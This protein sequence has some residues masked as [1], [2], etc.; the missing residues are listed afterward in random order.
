MS[1]KTIELKPAKVLKIKPKGK[2]LL[3]F[4]KEDAGNQNELVE[5]N[6]RIKELFGNARV[7]AIFSKDVDSV[8]I[9]ELM[10]VKENE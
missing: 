6:E 9:A 10:E 2:Y 5:L 7:L 8:K 4:D 1:K 3:I